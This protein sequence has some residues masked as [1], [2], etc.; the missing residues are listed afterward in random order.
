L[1]I[2]YE[3]EVIGVIGITG[4]PKKVEPFAEI[5]RRMTELIIRESYL[6]EQK[7]WEIRGLESFFYEWVHLKETRRV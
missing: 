7:Q 5:I 4:T 3:V 6:V 1:P 2:F